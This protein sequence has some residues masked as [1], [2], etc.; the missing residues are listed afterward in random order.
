MTTLHNYIGSEGV[1]IIR[2]EWC[3]QGSVSKWL[4]SAWR[5]EADGYKIAYQI[6][7]GLNFLHEQKII[8]RDL[9]PANILLKTEGVKV[10]V[11]KISDFG[12]ATELR[13]K[14]TSRVGTKSYRS[15]ELVRLSV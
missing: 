4:K 9:K 13:T 1:Y 8:H 6:A 10:L 15:P 7:S 14:M 12:L 2:T 11:V 3:D 5:C